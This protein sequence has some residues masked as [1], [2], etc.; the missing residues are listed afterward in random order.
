MKIRFVSKNQYKIAEV[1][2]MFEETNIE[3]VPTGVSISEIQS[4]DIEA[5]V[6]DK[7][8]KAFEIVGRPVF[9]EQTGLYIEQL[10]GFPGGLTQLFWDK[11]EAD[12]FSVLFGSGENTNILAK[13]YIGYC[14]AKRV[15]IFDGSIQGTI[16]PKPRGDRSFQW[17]CVF[18]PEGHTET[19]AEMGDKKND[20][21]MRRLAFDQ[22]RT[23]L[24]GNKL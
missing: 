1:K 9:V 24:M 14:D 3:I 20:I 8:M 11:L 2:G 18:I 12:K 13:T 19:F 5:I 21:S 16:A 7:L 4:D 10:N 22:F 15:E 17:D 6:K 23:F